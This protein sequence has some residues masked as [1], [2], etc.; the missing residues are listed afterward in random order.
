ME[1]YTHRER[2][3][4]ALNHKVPDRIP[5]DLGDNVCSMMKGSYKS[6]KTYLNLEECSYERINPEWDIV[7]EFDEKI[8]EL[9]DIDFRRVSL[10]GSSKYTRAISKDG[11]WVDEMGYKRKFT[12]MYGEII[13]HPFRHAESVSDIRNYNFYDA[14][15]PSRIEGLEERCKFL[16]FNTD[17]AIATDLFINGLVEAGLLMRG[18]DRFPIDLI[19]NKKMVHALFDKIRDYTIKLLDVFL[20][21][22]GPYIQIVEL[23][24]DWAM[25]NNV[26]FSPELYKKMVLPY[27]KEII[28]F[29][30]SK[31]E[32]KIFHHSCGSIIK[33][34]NILIE[35]GIDIINPLQP[36]ALGMDTTYLKDKFGGDLVFHG[37]VDEV[38]ILPFG[39]T[40]D[41]E[42]EVKRRIAIYGEDG[43][44]II[45]ASH[46][47][48]PDVPPENV[49]ALYN[50]AEKWGKYP[51]SDEITKI[52]KN[53]PKG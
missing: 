34:V 52:R 40:N 30:K 1:K 38:K 8:L 24:D 32:A 9:F 15:D 37:G 14:Y 36:T 20:N 27:Y 41:V 46:C 6:L 29:V 10:K 28:D 53:I 42:N 13:D 49:V 5:R 17:Y 44:Y 3:I 31:T 25:Q 23:T 45:C 50:S 43:G 11:I 12:G 33:I 26:F 39:N 19:Y 35:A 2:V 16:F 7:Q 47:I 48:Q 51:L 21:I 22:V 4:T 18:F